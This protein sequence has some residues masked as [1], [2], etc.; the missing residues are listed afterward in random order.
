MTQEFFKLANEYKAKHPRA[1][2][3]FDFLNEFGDE[4]L[5][6]IMKK[7]KGRKINFVPHPDNEQ[8]TLD[9]SHSVSYG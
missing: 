5:V 9:P 1:Q 3:P 6:E 7:A 4:A 8:Q 2:D